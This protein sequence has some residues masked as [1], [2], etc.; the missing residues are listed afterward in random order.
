MRKTFAVAC[1]SCYSWEK[2]A[3]VWPVQETPYYKKKEFAGKLLRLQANPQKPRKF[4]A[5][6]DLH[7]T[8]SAEAKKL[9]Y[10]NTF[11]SL[12]DIQ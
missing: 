5:T 4:S 9:L 10:Q 11:N 2:F 1:T 6:N 12:N 7:Y 3:I 8:V